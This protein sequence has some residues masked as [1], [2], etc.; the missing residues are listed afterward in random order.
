MIFKET[1]DRLMGELLEYLAR[2]DRVS[3]AAGYGEITVTCVIRPYNPA[4]KSY[5][6]GTPADP[7][8]QGGD[9]RTKDKPDG[10]RD[11][12]I[13]VGKQMR[14]ENPRWQMDPHPELVGTENEHIHIEVDDG[15]LQ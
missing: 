13:A 14:R 5:H 7:M 8:V 3:I 1:R 4:K 15:S 6:S 2:I 11:L 9:I 12:V 10:F